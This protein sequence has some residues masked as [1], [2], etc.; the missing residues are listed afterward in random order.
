MV[1]PKWRPKAR[2]VIAWGKKDLLVNSAPIISGTS[3]R[4]EA[5]DTLQ[6]P[7][8]H[9]TTLRHIQTKVM[10]QHIPFPML[11]RMGTL[12]LHTLPQVPL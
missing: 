3:L 10:K 5:L 8:P 6:H 12:P 7:L 1:T 2:L 9:M 11:T 4:M